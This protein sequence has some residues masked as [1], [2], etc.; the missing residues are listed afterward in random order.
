LQ[1]PYL[2]C[3][4]WYDHKGRKPE[5][6]IKIAEQLATRGRLSKS[7]AE[8]ILNKIPK[9]DYQNVKHHYKEISDAFD[10]LRHKSIIESCDTKNGRGKPERYYQITEQGLSGLI[11]EDPTP[12]KFWSLLIGFCHHRQEEVNREKV[13]RLFECFISKYLKYPSAYGFISHIDL[14]SKMC[15]VWI[16]NN[17]KK[18]AS[19][20]NLAQKI[21]EVLALFP[22]VTLHELS[23]KTQEPEEKVREA[24]N[25]YT[26]TTH[27]YTDVYFYSEDE[28][29]F[30]RLPEQYLDFLHH[31]IVI[32]NHNNDDRGFYTYEL[33][34][35]G[36]ILVMMLI[37]YHER[38]TYDTNLFNEGLSL[39]DYYY[40]ISSNYASKVPL[41]F[42]KWSLLK[43]H[44]KI[45]AE[46][47]FD[48]I[49]AEEKYRSTI[50]ESP[51]S[52]GGNKEYYQNMQSIVLYNNRQLKEI[53]DIGLSTCNRYPQSDLDDHHL[54]DY[55]QKRRKLKRNESKN[56]TTKGR[57]IAVYQK[58][59]EIYELLQFTN[60]VAYQDELYQKQREQ[61]ASKTLVGNE[62]Q[63]HG[64][65]HCL[66][67]SNGHSIVQ[68]IETGFA[69]EITFL[70]Y[71]NLHNDTYSPIL[72][73]DPGFQKMIVESALAR[74]KKAHQ[75]IEGDVSYNKLSS[76]ISPL[77]PKE[78]LS[79]VLRQDQDIR[80][81]FCL[82]MHD[83]IVY[84]NQTA[85]VM[86][87]S[88]NHIK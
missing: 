58:L 34:L 67:N 12:R 46:Y 88:Y 48:I 24:L 44:L 76:S 49:L 20:I 8:Y 25:H 15:N 82:C 4:R 39:S 74:I 81:W 37:R 80:N 23:I 9:Q 36:V 51:V 13:N 41:I 78:K 56:T 40:K 45:L 69:K 60:P 30:E 43:A 1:T 10:I 31:S 59:H 83:L 66:R 62:S 79:K 63:D 32:V 42:G 22:S 54:S 50:L 86:S 6:Q 3:K 77:S 27:L 47:N 65:D 26:M 17:V 5:L 35:F 75:S 64:H 21:L 84:Q 29:Y 38:N 68:I 61:K 33:S 18:N 7:K 14:F 57:I 85:E 70:Y 73:P 16:K 72:F 71:L 2:E 19:K 55:Q 11:A 87:Q 28:D 53:F 52:I